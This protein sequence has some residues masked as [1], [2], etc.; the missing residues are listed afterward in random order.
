[1]KSHR[2]MKTL[3]LYTVLGVGA[4]QCY[5]CNGSSTEPTGGCF[6]P[7]DSYPIGLCIGLRQCAQIF[8]Y[9]GMILL[10]AKILE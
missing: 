1:M 9:N 2:D 7:G 10:I 6:D 3:L 4:I 5:Y 8:N